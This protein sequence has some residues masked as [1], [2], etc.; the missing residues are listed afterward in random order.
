M[1]PIDD[2]YELFEKRVRSILEEKPYIL[3]EYGEITTDKSYII[4]T[5][6]TTRYVFSGKNH[7]L[8]L[9]TGDTREELEEVYKDYRERIGELKK[10]REPRLCPLQCIDCDSYT[11][12][13][14]YEILEEDAIKN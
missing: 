12:V 9:A 1:N 3:T 10:N 7:T 4:G 8:I 5:N 2:F 13:A 11:R 14:C 6:T